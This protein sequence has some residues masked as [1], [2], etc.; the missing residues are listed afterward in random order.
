MKT[1]RL[2]ALVAL[3]AAGAAAL[4]AETVPLLKQYANVLEA[5]RNDPASQTA[6]MKLPAPS[7]PTDPGQRAAFDE[8]VAALK[9]AA[10]K[11]PN[12]FF[13]AYN[14]YRALWKQYE[15]FGDLRAAADAAEQLV[16]ATKLADPF[17]NQSAMCA[18]SMSLNILGMDESHAKK[19]FKGTA[20]EAVIDLLT[21]ARSRARGADLRPRGKGPYARRATLA[22]G[23]LHAQAGNRKA[24][25]RLL[26]EAIRLDPKRGFV[27]NRA[28]DQLGRLML[29][30]ENIK[31]AEA[32]LES[33]GEVEP[34]ANLRNVGY[35]WRLARELIDHGRHKKAVAYLE[36]GFDVVT[37]AGTRPDP[38]L[39]YALAFGLTQLGRANDAL[40]YWGHYK[41][42]VDPNEEQR[43]KGLEI[44]KK[45]AVS[46]PI[47]P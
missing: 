26:R 2:L 28:Y 6:L 35:A 44:A 40:R 41:A 46:T 10:A 37:K 38:D 27:T 1:I 9:L 43:R 4:G 31:A 30:D 11:A 39:V 25:R 29:A 19:V 18:Y 3:T 13:V 47:E 34:D 16:K 23:I 36:R 17:S 7:D 20:R 24:A 33:A 42:L 22:L 21:T 15:Y 5:V 45:L 8:I 14:Y 12:D 32:M